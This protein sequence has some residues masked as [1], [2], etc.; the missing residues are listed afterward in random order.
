MYSAEM[1]LL[2]KNASLPSGGEASDACSG[3]GGRA[4]HSTPLE[5][6][7]AEHS[8]VKNVSS[9]MVSLELTVGLQEGVNSKDKQC[10]VKESSE[11][12]EVFPGD[13][14]GISFEQRGMES[15]T[16]SRK[17]AERSV[18][19]VSDAEEY[20]VYHPTEVKGAGKQLMCVTGVSNH[21]GHVPFV[22]LEKKQVES[23][24]ECLGVRTSLVSTVSERKRLCDEVELSC[25]CRPE[26]LAALCLNG[27]RRQDIDVNRT[28]DGS[29]QSQGTTRCK[30]NNETLVD[31]VRKTTKEEN[32][33]GSVSSTGQSTATDDNGSDQATK[34]QP[35]FGPSSEVAGGGGRA[36]HST[37]SGSEDGEKVTHLKVIELENIPFIMMIEVSKYTGKV[38]P[39]SN[40]E[41][42]DFST[43][44]RSFED[45][46]KF[47]DEMTPEKKL[48]YFL[49]L[50]GE[51]ARDR[52]DEAMRNEPTISLEDLIKHLKYRYENPMY[53]WRY[54]DQLR[55]IKR[56]H[57]ESVNDF[58]SRVTKLARKAHDGSFNDETKTMII[59]NFF[60]GLEPEM[61]A[62]VQ[63]RDPKTVEDYLHAALLGELNKT[64][65]LQTQQI[66][67]L[68]TNA[69]NEIRSILSKTTEHVNHWLQREEQCRQGSHH[70][71]FTEAQV[72]SNQVNPEAQQ[73]RRNDGDGFNGVNQLLKEDGVNNVRCFYC[74]NIGHIA[75]GCLTKK[76]DK[77]SQKMQQSAN[78]NDRAVDQGTIQGQTLSAA[79]AEKWKPIEERFTRTVDNLQEQLRASQR[80]NEELL[81]AQGISVPDRRVM[82]VHEPKCKDELA[83]KPID[84]PGTQNEDTSSFIVAQVPVRANGYLCSALIDTGACISVA[85]SEA[86]TLL[87]LFNLEPSKSTSALGLGGSPVQ[88][89][90]SHI[91]TFQIGSLDICQRVHFTDGPCSPGR[92][93]SYLFI[94]GNDVLS[95]LPRFFIDYGHKEFHFGEDVL[96]LGKGNRV[97]SKPTAS[98]DVNE[99]A[100]STMLTVI[101]PLD[102][103][104][105]ATTNEDFQANETELEEAHEYVMSNNLLT[106]TPQKIASSSTIMSPEVRQQPSKP[107]VNLNQ[108]TRQKGSS[109]RK[110]KSET[111]QFKDGKGQAKNKDGNPCRRNNHQET[112]GAKPKPKENVPPKTMTRPEGTIKKSQV[113]AKLKVKEPTKQFRKSSR[114][115][116]SSLEVSSQRQ[117]NSQS[118]AFSKTRRQ[119]ASQGD[120][121]NSRNDAHQLSARRRQPSCSMGVKKNDP[122]G[123]TTGSF[124]KKT[125][126]DMGPR[127]N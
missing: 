11:A 102:S 59:N 121:L 1:S 62:F 25:V 101:E 115:N 40:P 32:E 65:S 100:N 109:P 99:E 112:N 10:K 78:R 114:Q 47:E 36:K 57:G 76:A 96:P 44:L 42:Q 64:T 54:I 117:T 119:P 74:N 19:S 28:R 79:E 66:T 86:A 33:A 53:R 39:F 77:R 73:S 23:F 90:G 105:L 89:K 22:N 92:A 122:K 5:H 85:S 29:I 71:R 6:S 21:C 50:L 30:R 2:G 126:K 14:F 127:P 118:G 106:S 97:L 110:S 75:S 116:I 35:S 93:D 51:E 15:I 16:L 12:E 95:R 123:A 82:M 31:V 20:A 7:E 98:E 24:T 60:C 41:F 26:S 46:C 80:R 81:A 108:Y 70:Q 113:Q 45:N 88:M 125:N 49:M 61:R 103:D 83:Q 38:K 52:A 67:P 91:V 9:P 69:F 111:D 107:A 48:A 27:Q 34:G 124:T 8:F 120:K 4:K 94:L 58:Y 63:S 56:D 37:S 68:S 104:A 87:G 18:Q 17:I 72:F 13:R 3:E 43:F 84:A 55:A